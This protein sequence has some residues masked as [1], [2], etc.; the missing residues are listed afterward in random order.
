MRK[1]LFW[2][3]D[4]QWERVNLIC[5]RMCAVSSGRTTGA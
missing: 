2:L 1:N 3:S 4:E 5:R